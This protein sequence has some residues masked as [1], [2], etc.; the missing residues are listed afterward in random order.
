MGDREKWIGDVSP[1]W[2]RALRFGL[3][4]MLC[5][6]GFLP[7]V[8][9]AAPARD[10][11]YFAGVA[12]TGYAVNIDTSFPHISRLLGQH[13]IAMLNKKLRARITRATLPETISFDSLGSIKDASRATALA[14]GLNSESTTI[15]HIGSVYKLR[16]EISA[17]A[18]FFNFHNK[19]VLGG[20]PFIIDYITVLQAAP[21][22]R[23]IDDAYRQIIF[24]AGDMH[25][26]AAVFTSTLARAQVPNPSSK[27][28]RVVSST[29]GP[30]AIAYLKRYAPN[31]DINALPQQVAQ[32]FGTY[33]AA[34]Q[35]ISI[36]PY[37]SS[38]AIGSAM[39]ARFVQGSA[40]DL[41]V[42]QADYA[43]KLNV[44]GFKKLVSSHSDVATVYLYGAFVDVGVLEPLSGH[45]YFSQRLKQG[46]TKTVPASQSSVDNWGPTFDT[47]KTLFSNFTNSLTNAD[48][49]WLKYGMPKG[50]EAKD[51][52]KSLKELIAS[53]R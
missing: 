32:A 6:V 50:G 7:A 49:P 24:G 28:L 34:N 52:F 18:L 42:P 15:E 8:A 25:S 21:T 11:V 9:L 53:C 33:L 2:P 1:R 13:G 38:Q 37:S 41:R 47:L 43:I 4:I 35:H 46:L 45:V 44:A 39:A 51:Q 29:L 48:N 22:E 17:Q 36:L 26:L 3:R 12:Y 20:F 10:T 19:Q 30:K 5:C 31:V 16:V 27:H 40:Y 23:D 14:L